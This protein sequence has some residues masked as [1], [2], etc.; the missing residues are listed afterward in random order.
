VF[1]GVGAHRH[2]PQGL[3]ESATQAAT[4]ASAARGWGR[5]WTPVHIDAVGLPPMLVDWLGSRA[6]QLSTQRLLA[7]FDE[8]DEARAEAAV[9]TLSTYLDEHGSL[10]R[11][12]ERLHLHKNAVAY[13]M[14][15]IREQLNGVDLEDPDRRLELQLACRAWLLTR[16]R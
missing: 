5:P 9:R 3:R 15:R 4:A 12:A 6:A 16:T 10:T 14:R 13:R 8:L 11:S 1:C 2:G 7:P